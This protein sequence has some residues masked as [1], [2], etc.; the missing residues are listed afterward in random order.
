MCANLKYG[1]KNREIFLKVQLSL[2]FKNNYIS[3]TPEMWHLF[4]QMVNPQKENTG[5]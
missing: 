2:S 3:G 4:N 1:I 5:S